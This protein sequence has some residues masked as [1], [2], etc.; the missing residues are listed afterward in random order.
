MPVALVI[1]AVVVAWIVL[2]ILAVCLCRSASDGDLN[3]RA[4]AR[5]D[6]AAAGASPA[7]PV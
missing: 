6:R 3:L 5:R 4:S 7:V 1:A 2:S